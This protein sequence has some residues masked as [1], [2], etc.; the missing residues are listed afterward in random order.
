MVTFLLKIM[1]CQLH[2]VI[3]TSY[4]LNALQDGDVVSDV[5]LNL[6]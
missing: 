4:D 6:S 2:E 5:N 3:N 1:F